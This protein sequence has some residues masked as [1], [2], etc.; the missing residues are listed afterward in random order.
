MTTTRLPLPQA[1][2]SVEADGILLGVDA[3]IEGETGSAVRRWVRRWL[4]RTHAWLIRGL[5][6]AGVAALFATIYAGTSEIQRNIIA[7]RVLK[8]PR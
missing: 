2:E 5:T 4:W 3:I 8:L 7:E 6:L 1:G